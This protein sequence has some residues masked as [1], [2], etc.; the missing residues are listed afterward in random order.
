[1]V[2]WA[3]RQHDR[4]GLSGC[5]PSEPGGESHPG[6]ALMENEHGPGALADDEVAL[7]MTGLGSGIDILG[8]L[9]DG[10]AILDHIS[11]RPRPARTAAFVTARE[12]TPQLL[13]LLSGAID[14]SVDRLAADGSPD[15]VHFLVSASPRFAR[16]ST[17]PR[18]AVANEGP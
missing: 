10:D 2:S 5:F 18:E 8:P 16:A 6:F 12:I 17:L 3:D 4:D 14:E 15:G 9:V 7:P 13:G 1:M 11:R